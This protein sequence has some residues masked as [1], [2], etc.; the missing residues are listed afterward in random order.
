MSQFPVLPLF[1]S[2][3][4]Y[5]Y[6]HAHTRHP[7]IMD[8][9]AIDPE[10]RSSQSS[11]AR[12]SD[13]LSGNTKLNRSLADP[14]SQTLGQQQGQFQ[15]QDG[16]DGDMTQ[17]SQYEQLS[18]NSQD[19]SQWQQRQSQPQ[20]Q[21]QSQQR[22]PSSGNDRSNRNQGDQWAQTGEI[23]DADQDELDEADPNQG[24]VYDNV[25]YN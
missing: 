12:G 3:Q 2:A 24:N 21:A 16:R 25:Q 23:D 19:R 10:Y 6:T 4:T 14:Q 1:F 9:A 15:F 5:D 7:T 13:S 8:R 20:S 22:Y 11:A 18:Q 17:N